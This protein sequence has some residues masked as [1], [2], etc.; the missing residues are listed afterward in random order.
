MWPLFFPLTWVRRYHHHPENE[1]EII[2]GVLKPCLYLVF[3]AC[4]YVLLVPGTVM[5]PSSF[6]VQKAWVLYEDYRN[7]LTYY[8][9]KTNMNTVIEQE[10]LK[11][12]VGKS[13]DK[14]GMSSNHISVFWDLGITTNLPYITGYVRFSSI[15]P[16]RTKLESVRPYNGSTVE[17]YYMGVSL[18]SITGHM[19]HIR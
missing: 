7:I 13:L 12:Y 16:I 19:S 4:P 6:A 17:V 11:E 9:L 3:H 14:N 8:Q 5:K 10:H 2:V 15:I 1:K 18:G